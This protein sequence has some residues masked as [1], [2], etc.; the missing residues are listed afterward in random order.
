[1]RRIALN[2]EL[3]QMCIARRLGD[4]D[5]KLLDLVL[6]VRRPAEGPHRIRAVEDDEGAG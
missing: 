6:L 5:L 1:M 4:D 3:K 2:R